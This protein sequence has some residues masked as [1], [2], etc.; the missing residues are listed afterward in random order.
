MKQES[1]A[2]NPYNGIFGQHLRSPTINQ[3]GIK[4]KS[5]TIMPFKVKASSGPEYVMLMMV[6]SI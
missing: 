3:G 1:S 6:V 2:I 5:T 4:W